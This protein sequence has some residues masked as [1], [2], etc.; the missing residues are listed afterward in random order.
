MVVKPPIFLDTRFNQHFKKE[1]EPIQFFLYDRETNL[2]FGCISEIWLGNDWKNKLFYKIITA[3][4]RMKRSECPECNF[5]LLER[6][7]QHG[8]RFM[9]CSGFPDC[10]Y[11]AEVEEIYDDE[12]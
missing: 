9:G 7:T 12:I 1:D 4:D 3:E 10:E 8:H 11:S 5:W 2:V 6:T